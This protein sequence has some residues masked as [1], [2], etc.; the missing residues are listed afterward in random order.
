MGSDMFSIKGHMTRESRIR[1]SD[2]EVLNDQDR[3]TIPKED[4][5]VKT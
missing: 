5:R 3:R 2:S 4:P 1:N